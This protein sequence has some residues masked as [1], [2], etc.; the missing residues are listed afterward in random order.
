MTPPSPPRRSAD[1]NR[2]TTDVED[3]ASLLLRAAEGSTLRSG[4]SNVITY[5]TRDSRFDPRE[6]FITSLR[7]EF[8]GLGGDVTFVRGTA[9]AGYYHPIFEDWTISVRGTGGTMAGIGE[10]TLISDRFFKGGGQPR[11]FEY[12]GIGPRDAKT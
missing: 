4:I 6:G 10:D 3:D 9:S 2:Q 8:F 12:G 5:D 7:T 1:L 11:G